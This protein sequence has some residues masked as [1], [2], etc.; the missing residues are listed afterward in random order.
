[1]FGFNH[2]KIKIFCCHVTGNPSREGAAGDVLVVVFDQD[3][4]VSRQDGQV[5]HSA[6]PVLVVQTA[7]VRLGWT[8]DGQRQTSYRDMDMN[9]VS[10]VVL[11]SKQG[12]GQTATYPLRHL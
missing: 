7:D 10:V 11:K 8:L 6:R 1:M 5:G 2:K 3:A 12:S 9:I 4:V